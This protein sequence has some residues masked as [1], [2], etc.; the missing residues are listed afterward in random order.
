MQFKRAQHSVGR[1]KLANFETVSGTPAQP[2]GLLQHLTLKGPLPG[3]VTIGGEIRVQLDAQ[4]MERLQG[5]EKE[6]AALL[7]KTI[8]DFLNG[9]GRE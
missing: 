6:L 9:G 1:F 5:R 2:S 8:G 7:G 4:S 3:P